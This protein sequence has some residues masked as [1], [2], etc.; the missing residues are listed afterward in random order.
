MKQAKPGQV[1]DHDVNASRF[2][3]VEGDPMAVY[4]QKW[5]PIGGWGGLLTPLR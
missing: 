5:G 1:L 3:W 4:R 2:Q